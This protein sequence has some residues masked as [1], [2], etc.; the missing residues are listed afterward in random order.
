[1]AGAHLRRAVAL[2]PGMLL[3]ACASTIPEPGLAPL[4]PLPATETARA[5]PL[6]AGPALSR[7]RIAAADA[8]AALAAFRESCPKLLIRKDAS[9]L[10]TGSH[11]Q[12]ACKAATITRP[13]KARAFFARHF[14]TL[15]VGSGEA[16]ATGYFEPVILGARNRLPGLDVPVYGLPDDLLRARPGDAEPLASG[17]MP[18]GR[19][20][21]QGRFRPYFTRAEIEDGALAG[22]GLEIAWVADAIDFFF[23]QIQGSGRLVAPDGSVM[24]IGY[25]GQN[26]HPYTAIGALMRARGLLGDGP[27]QYPASMQGIMRYLRDRPEEG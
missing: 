1:M 10:A 14:E 22:R 21:S 2:A 16:L 23:L 11:W 17:A 20:D 5:L 13:G 18:L 26:G 6:S 27:G 15:R 25:A 3:A 12:A 7:L 24:R 4:P 8:A 19:Y 9:G